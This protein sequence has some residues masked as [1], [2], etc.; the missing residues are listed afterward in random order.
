MKKLLITIV[1]LTLTLIMSVS[2]VGCSIFDKAPADE[3]PT[4]E[5]TGTT[6][7]ESGNKESTST[8]TASTSSKKNEVQRV[9]MAFSAGVTVDATETEPAHV[10]KRLEAVVEPV[11]A[12]QE[13]DYTV[14]WQEGA[15]LA[16]EDVS[17]YLKVEQDSDGSLGATVKCYKAFGSDTIVITCTTRSR[18]KQDVC[19]VTFE[20]LTKDITVTHSFE[21]TEDTRGTFY[22]VPAGKSY[23]LDITISSIFGDDYTSN[24][25]MAT[26]FSVKG[27]GTVYVLYGIVEDDSLMPT[28]PT[29]AYVYPMSVQEF[30]NS[31]SYR[32]I[33]GLQAGV[34]G[35][36]LYNV[37][38]DTQYS[39]VKYEETENWLTHA[40]EAR[41]LTFN[42][43]DFLKGKCAFGGYMSGN[44]LRD[45]RYMFMT[46]VYNDTDLIERVVICDAEG[47]Q[48]STTEYTAEQIIEM[49]KQALSDA[50]FEVS[51]VD[52][53]SG[54]ESEV[55]RFWPYWPENVV[56][57]VSGLPENIV[58]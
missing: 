20:G 26:N 51:V 37:S 16:S 41:Y 44:A 36:G 7:T 40:V 56:H 42:I 21:K 38:D 1:A 29:T 53:V 57:D 31:I 10:T 50:C 23:K 18:Q 22:Y 30:F 15:S 25:N 39:L 33:N 27:T 54:S 49:N 58:I 13:V 46:T 32:K 5:T 19:L 34:I 48:T 43:P 17:T 24:V 8:G 9:A 14:A 12:P 45:T 52:S 55:I 35:G 47:N 6:G 2:M 28:E 11:T 4:T 3:T